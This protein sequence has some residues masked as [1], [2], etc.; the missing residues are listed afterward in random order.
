MLLQFIRWFMHSETL[1]F[2]SHLTTNNRVLLSR[3]NR[4]HNSDFT[5]SKKS[6]KQESD[7]YESFFP[8]VT[9]W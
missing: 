7:Y 6:L 8:K 1:I 2:I 3:Q 4:N 5:G 9:S